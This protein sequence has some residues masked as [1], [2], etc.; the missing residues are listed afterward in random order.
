[1]GH[2]HV[3]FRVSVEVAGYDSKVY[4]V[5]TAAAD[6]G[7]TV[8]RVPITGNETVL[9]AIGHV[10]GLPSPSSTKIWVARPGPPGSGKE[11]VLPVDW[12][13]VSRR[14]ATATNYQLLPG[15]RVFI[16]EEDTR[17]K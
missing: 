1:M 11:T 13:S 7:D 2:A 9:E 12:Q 14:G 16:A 15:D 5:I 8:V 6:K 17:Q 10:G 3:D 4:Y